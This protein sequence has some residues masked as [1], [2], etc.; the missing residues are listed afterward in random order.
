MR[1]KMVIQLV[2]IFPLSHQIDVPLNQNNLVRLIPSL[3]IFDM[4]DTLTQFDIVETTLIEGKSSGVQVK[5]GF[6]RILLYHLVNTYFPMLCLLI[7]VE[8]TLFFEQSQLQ[9]AIA[10]ALTVLLVMY[11]MYQ[12]ISVSQP[13]TAYL[14]YMDYWIFFCLLVPFIVF[15]IEVYWELSRL[16]RGKKNRE[17]QRPKESQM[18]ILSKGIVM[19]Y[20]NN[21][22]GDNEEV[23]IPLRGEVRIVT[24]SLTAIF[25][26]G[27][28]VWGATI[29]KFWVSSNQQWKRSCRWLRLGYMS[30]SDSKEENSVRVEANWKKIAAALMTFLIVDWCFT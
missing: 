9:A 24:V 30:I 22:V 26:F 19:A 17:M 7:I 2:I 14:K 13:K 27:Y 1:F 20:N 11:T 18:R 21:T 8:L 12:G 10:L 23:K 6:Q 28:I 4:E 29:K 25:I 5:L 3:L 16:R 15:L